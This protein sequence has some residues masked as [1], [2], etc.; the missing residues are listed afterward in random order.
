MQ[1]NNNRMQNVKNTYAFTFKSQQSVR[2]DTFTVFG[3]F[4]NFSVVS[5]TMFGTCN[6]PNSH[7]RNTHT[8]TLIS[9]HSTN[10]LGTFNHNTRYSHSTQ[11]SNNNTQYACDTHSSACAMAHQRK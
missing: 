5:T 10:T 11:P 9:T 3:A 2:F 1:K 6:R 4:N 8:N 7:K